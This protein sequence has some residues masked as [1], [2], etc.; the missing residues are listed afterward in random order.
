MSAPAPAPH[1]V[2][3]DLTALRGRRAISP[4]SYCIAV[5][6]L[7]LISYEFELLFPFATRA[8]ALL[9]ASIA[10][11]VAALVL[12]LADITVLRRRTRQGTAGILVV[13]AA[14][15]ACGLARGLTGAVASHILVAKAA[16]AEFALHFLGG[17]ILVVV[18]LVIVAILLVSTDRDR[19]TTRALLSRQ[20]QLRRQLILRESA[21]ARGR[22][23]IAAI[24]DSVVERAAAA[25]DR[26]AA[27]SPALAAPALASRLADLALQIRDGAE[28]EVRELSHVLESGEPQEVPAAASP[29]PAPA[30]VRGPHD[31]THGREWAAQAVRDALIID[32]I[33]PTAV[34]LTA[35]VIALPLLADEYHFSY[36]LAAM[37]L[38]A[39]VTFSF[40]SG[41]RLLLAGRL[42]RWTAPVRALS[43]IAVTAGAA[44]L[45]SVVLGWMFPDSV[46]FDLFDT[47]L[48]TFELFLISGFAWAIIAASNI[49][50][51]RAQHSLAAAV[52]E[53]EL[54]D[55]VLRRELAEVERQAADIVH[56]RVQSRIIAAGMM[57]S[58]YAR[59]VRDSASDSEAVSRAAEVL[60]EASGIL[61]AAL[62]DAE[63]I[64][65]PE[66][67]PESADIGEV[68]TAIAAAWT[69]AV[70]VQ[71]KIADSDRAAIDRH[72]GAGERLS[73]TVRDAIANAARHGSATEVLIDASVEGETIILH[74]R[75]NG[76]VV[77]AHPRPGLGLSRITRLNGTW[78]LTPNA[79]SG[80]T[81][82]TATLP[83]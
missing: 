57:I 43:L 28:G 55:E 9:I 78:T 40:L 37:F 26:L 81:T 7:F 72:R 33:Q 64:A 54:H 66:L 32:P 82:L 79:P 17:V 69:G 8:D 14:Y 60:A 53:I 44:A 29:A 39:S 58:L 77:S 13:L 63:Q 20:D 83:F 27:E 36:L 42:R 21:L 74:V 45:A 47:A 56:G 10:T 25:C 19:D 15:T 12:Y 71:F 65:D 1:A 35:V 23:A 48:R 22:A 16:S 38:S 49:R 50:A 31:R 73:Q 59:E 46:R 18:W 24:I 62:V 61:R 4:L 80:G 52:S 11:P 2:T 41:A 6:G 3:L 75:D 70:S 68:L 76:T 30:A 5:P 67:G 51:W 34:T